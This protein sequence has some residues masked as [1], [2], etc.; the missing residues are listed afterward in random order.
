MSNGGGETWQRKTGAEK[1][2]AYGAVVLSEMCPRGDCQ[3]TTR[4]LPLILFGGLE[5]GEL[6][7]LKPESGVTW[8]DLCCLWEITLSD[9]GI[10]GLSGE[11]GDNRVKAS[12][13]S[14]ER[15]QPEIMSL[16]T[17]VDDR[18][19]WNHDQDMKHVLLQNFKRKVLNKSHPLINLTTLPAVWLYKQRDSL[20]TCMF[21]VDW[22]G[23]SAPLRHS[24]LH[25]DRGPPRG[26]LLFSH[27]ERS[28]CWELSSSLNSI[29]PS[30][31]CPSGHMSPYSC[32]EAGK[33]SFPWGQKAVV[34]LINL[35]HVCCE[36]IEQTKNHSFSAGLKLTC[37]QHLNQLGYKNH[38]LWDDC[39][40]DWVALE[41]TGH[42]MM[43]VIQ[44]L[45][46]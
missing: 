33:D 28:R 29:T 32:R 3:A 2:R 20:F 19:C 21:M 37:I 25:T 31:P 7:A 8:F 13:D 27:G 26:T 39:G 24:G 6:M 1:E 5:E 15:K 16:N 22:L 34:G 43:G 10:V 23:V 17:N 44:I 41:G 12:S 11:Q 36:L 14:V 46:S 9:V 40:I 18:S 30:V 42:P 38:L 45:V 4:Y 35:I